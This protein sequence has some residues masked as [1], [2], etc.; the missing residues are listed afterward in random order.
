[1][2]VIDVQTQMTTEKGA[3]FSKDL[4]D[5]FEVTF[6][7]II[8]Y[9]QTEDEMMNVFRE[10]G[11]KVVFCVPEPQNFDQ[12]AETG[13]YMA[14]LKSDYPDVVY[15][16]WAPYNFAKF[17]DIDKYVI[18]LEKYIDKAKSFGVFYYGA[19]T[20]VPA[21]D[22]R[23][24]PIY[25]LCNDKKLPIKISVGHTAMGAGTPGGSGIRLG[26]ERPIPN[27]DD[28]AAQFP[29]LNIIAAH[30]PWPFHSEMISVLVHKANVY[31]EV[32]GWMPKYFPEEL[33]KEINSRCKTKI[34]FGSDYP[35]FSFDRILKG[36]EDEGYKPEVLENVFYKNAERVF[37][38]EY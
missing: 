21:N 32:H 6:K 7:T 4:K 35:F 29:E 16:S 10:A 13:D 28:V 8:P 5:F 19:A 17:T 9:Y 34:M 2:K 25:Q 23:F 1:M 11:V 31:N 30:C 38:I 37:G 24:F 20:G 22:K 18:E 27:V 36:W 12:M 26:T 14:K 33:K 15:G 3:M